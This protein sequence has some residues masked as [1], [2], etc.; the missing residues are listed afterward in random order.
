MN[1]EIKVKLDNFFANFQNRKY[2]QGEVI[3]RGDENPPGV[4]YLVSGTVHQYDI[5]K[6]GNVIILNIIRTPAIF[7][8]S[9]VMNDIQNSFFFE[10]MEPVELW[11]APQK[12][13]L[14]MIR[15]EPDILFELLSRVY[16]GTDGVLQRI[17]HLMAASAYNRV[18]LELIISAKYLG[19]QSQRGEVKLSLTAGDL[20]ERT[21]LTRE[22]V[23]RE[24]QKLKTEGL[25]RV[26]LGIIVLP[27]LEAL[28][29]A[30]GLGI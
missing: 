22:T 6:Q 9:W 1:P 11:M 27:D 5:T 4:L 26:S 14:D 16:R 18:V 13:T 12:E 8:M 25:V 28:E 10:A 19:P 21:G 23:S 24:L 15:S 17:T 2:R 30:H 29:D 20:A 3:I 7:P